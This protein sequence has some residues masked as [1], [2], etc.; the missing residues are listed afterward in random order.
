M[1]TSNSNAAPRST[2]NAR[3]GGHT[4]STRH[5]RAREET[6]DEEE[7]G[8]E[9]HYKKAR[10]HQASASQ[11][12]GTRQIRRPAQRP[13]RPS[14]AFIRSLGEHVGTRAP[15]RPMGG[16]ESNIRPSNEPRANGRVPYAASV[17]SD[18]AA[19]APNNGYMDITISV[20]I[21]SEIVVKPR[22]QTYSL[23]GTTIPGQNVD[24]KVVDRMAPTASYGAE[25]PMSGTE[26]EEGDPDWQGHQ[27]TARSSNRMA[28]RRLTR[29]FNPASSSGNVRPT[30]EDC[31]PPPGLPEDFIEEGFEPEGYEDAVQY[32]NQSQTKNYDL[33]SSTMGA[34]CRTA[35]YTDQ[36]QVEDFDLSA[37]ALGASL[38]TSSSVEN[39]QYYP[40]G[41]QV[42]GG[43]DV[44]DFAASASSP[45]FGDNLTTTPEID[46]FSQ[47]EIPLYTIEELDQLLNEA[48]DV[49]N[50]D[51]MNDMN[52]IADQNPTE[53]F[54][55]PQ[56]DT[57]GVPASDFD[58]LTYEQIQAGYQDTYGR[59]LFDDNFPLG[60]DNFD[61]TNDVDFLQ[62][63]P[64]ADIQGQGES[65]SPNLGEFSGLT[66]PQ[67]VTPETTVSS[68]PVEAPEVPVISY[69]PH[70]SDSPEP[71]WDALFDE[72]LDKVY[73]EEEL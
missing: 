56:A 52:A 54:A 63:Q 67:Q 6:D 25:P 28:N 41:T 51:F 2:N 45:R 30:V 39:Q 16:L 32:Q 8:N 21:G 59:P 50:A 46:Y 12:S 34:S 35:Q 24:W 22:N 38:D 66:T 1:Q 4:N 42:T 47:L 58:D 73:V 64:L 71:D 43:T 55:Q 14:Q 40:A 44:L 49:A 69:P 19:P 36:T 23:V 17:A 33:S 18:N 3:F 10:V 72:D 26:Q 11:A 60:D 57:L 65:S 62:D 20:P 68:D 53:T 48:D 5:K 37:S 70:D 27:I 13:Y 29:T 7:E 31:G 15:P 61:P 9:M